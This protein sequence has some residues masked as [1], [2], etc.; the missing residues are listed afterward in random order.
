MRLSSKS[1]RAAAV[2]AGLAFSCAFLFP[3]HAYSLE[4][5]T[6][7]VET[8]AVTQAGSVPPDIESDELA[9]QPVAEQHLSS[10]TQGSADQS[11]PSDSPAA[12]DSDASQVEPAPTDEQAVPGDVAPADEAQGNGAQPKATG[13]DSVSGS[14]KESDAEQERPCVT[15]DAHVQN[16]GWQA[17]PSNPGGWHSDGETAG[18]TGKALRMEGIRIKLDSSL[19]GSITYQAHVQN[20]GWQAWVSDGALAGTTGKSL[21]LE[22]LRIALQGDV[23]SRYSVYYRAHVQ[24]YGW[25]GWTHDGASVGSAG[26][27]LRLEALEI[28]LIEKSQA[29]QETQQVKVAFI[30]KAALTASGHVQDLGWQHVQQVGIG[31]TIT[32]GTTGKSKRLEAFSIAISPD[33]AEG[34]GLVS[35]A[36][37]SNIGWQVD[38]SD[39]HT[40]KAANSQA[41]RSS[42]GTTGKSLSLEAV[43][44]RLS[45]QLSPYYEIYYRAHV[46]DLGWLD[47]TKDGFAAGTTGLGMRLEALQIRLQ[48]KGSKAPGATSNSYTSKDLW[49]DVRVT[50]STPSGKEVGIGVSAVRG[51]GYVFLPSFSDDGTAKVSRAVGTGKFLVSGKEDGAFHSVDNGMSISLADINPDVCEDG[52]RTIFYQGFSYVAPQMLHLLKSSGVDAMFLT[53]DDPTS[54]GRSYV[55]NSADHSAK[56][57]G[58]MILANA[59]GSVVY[60]GALT[61]IKG[62][63]NTTWSASKKPYQ[64][65]LSDKCDLLET[66]DSDN[67]SKTWVLLASAYDPTKLFNAIAFA[68]GKNIGIISPDCK[69]VDLYYDGDYRGSYLLAEKVQVGSGRVDIHDLEKDVEKANAQVDL[70]SLE[71]AT[72]VNAFGNTYQYVKNMANPSDISGGYL[73]ELDNNWYSSEASWFKTSV[74][75]FVVKSP[76][77]SSKDSMRQISEAFQEAIDNASNAD[78]SYHFDLDSLARVLLLNTFVRN[79]DFARS[80]TYY[81]VDR[82]SKTIF[83]GPIW[84][85]DQC[86]GKIGNSAA[87]SSPAGNA[88]NNH[89]SVG[90]MTAATERTNAIK[91]A[92][93][94]VRMHIEK[95][96]AGDVA[97]DIDSSFARLSKLSSDSIG[98]D[99][100][101]WQKKTNF[102]AIKKAQAEQLARLRDWMDKRVAWMDTYVKSL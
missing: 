31:T 75:T 84:D 68:L 80:S 2:S 61:Q 37:V 36:H 24:N 56:A 10:S 78:E 77:F 53:S 11:Q 64:I 23:A 65:K 52:S 45:S 89:N 92:W 1:I 25:L 73:V 48:V 42:N 67:R 79:T 41:N 12:D 62:R 86:F 66:G 74:A 81:Y 101:L 100:V 20:V 29:S 50:T 6:N 87:A 39:P 71:R 28:K 16:V 70:S 32:L 72:D 3:I 83:S 90:W 19:S 82:D 49:T 93:P 4:S 13:N 21:R 54:M 17:S 88:Y 14:S 102:T 47:W 26:L 69:M 27:G 8:A 91:E 30:P 96:I 85:F 22:A 57:T 46:E 38:K 44:L 51:N 15:Y 35:N 95:F 9:Q 76:E 18:T 63:G 98:M 60:D 58:S 43:Q 59:K 99:V 40:W 55:E 33:L 94:E 97:D 5:A 7:P 34:S